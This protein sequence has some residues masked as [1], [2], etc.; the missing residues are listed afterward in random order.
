MTEGAVTTAGILQALPITVRF[1]SHQIESWCPQ[2]RVD[3][4][5]RWYDLF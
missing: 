2:G 5:D 3:R 4:I 1:G